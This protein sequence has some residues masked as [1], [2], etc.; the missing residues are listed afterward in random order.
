MTDGLAIGVKDGPLS[1]GEM[2]SA[3][4]V[5]TPKRPREA[6]RSSRGWSSSFELLP[7]DDK[8]DT[9]AELAP[10]YRATSEG[11]SPQSFSASRPTTA[12]ADRC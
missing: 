2:G 3:F 10:N 1:F 4:R 6:T 12:T 9:Q 11:C 5:V 8:D 7:V